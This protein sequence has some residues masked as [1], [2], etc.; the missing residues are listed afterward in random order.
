MSGKKEELIPLNPPAVNIY[1]CGPTTYNFIHLGNAR[2]LAVF[3]TLRRYLDYKGYQVNYVQNFTDIDDKIINKAAEEKIDS[4]QLAERYI[5]EYFIDADAIGIK[6]ADK[7]P[8]VSEH[9]AE[10]ISLISTLIE[11]GYAYELE[12]DVYYRVKAFRDY[13]KLS[14]RSLEDMRAGA[15]IEVDNRKED[16]ADFALWKKAK[17]G[18][19]AWESPWGKGRPGWHIECSAMSMKY[20]GPTIDIHGGGA[21]L[22]FPHHENEIAQS[23]AATE[24]PFSKY[25]M[26]NGFITVNNEKM[27]KSLGNF[28]IL[29]DILEKYSGDVI[30]FYLI[31]THYRSPLDFDDTKL[32]ESKKALGRLKNTLQLIEE[33]KNVNGEWQDNDSVPEADE[34]LKQVEKNQALFLQAMDDDLNTAKAVGYLF[35]ISHAINIF[36]STVSKKTKPAQ[37]AIE[38]AEGIFK[39]LGNILGIFINGK[40]K[41]NSLEEDV[42]RVLADL[43]NMARQEKDYKLADKIRDVLKDLEISLEDSNEG[44]RIIY[45]NADIDIIIKEIIKIRMELKANKKYKWADFIRDQLKEV[46]I[47]LEDTREGARYKIVDA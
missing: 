29:R 26:H 37:I 38:K 18:E 20:L 22:I 1:V 24:K 44:T 6:R 41:L 31:A 46:G 5:G 39:D 42:I 16:V 13:G 35:E 34:L 4:L 10:I 30:R 14:G 3:D 40:E 2:P 21:D 43:R 47:V 36:M 27:S 15:R 8:R 9:L 45:E 28:F 19:P 25:W 33:F 17:P 32:T 7:Y 11:K 12:G 23:E